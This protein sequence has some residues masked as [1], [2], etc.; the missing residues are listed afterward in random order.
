MKPGIL[1]IDSL[2]DR[3]E[4]SILLSKLPP[5]KRVAFMAWCA[6]QTQS[7]GRGVGYVPDWSMVRDAERSDRAD[8]RLTTESYTLFLVMV[9][10]WNLD[11]GKAVIQLER[12]ARLRPFDLPPVPMF[13]CPATGLAIYGHPVGPNQVRVKEYQR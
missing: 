11:V 9:A 3:K 13:Q 5:R 4:V 2:D 7:G 1:T 10:Q 6:R 8:D 12:A